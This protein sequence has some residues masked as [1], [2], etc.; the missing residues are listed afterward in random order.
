M[1]I[2]RS[3]APR[4]LRLAELVVRSAL[5]VARRSGWVPPRWRTPRGTARPAPTTSSIGIVD[6]PDGGVRLVGVRGW[7]GPPEVQRLRTI[8]RE[9]PRGRALHLDLAGA[10][11]WPHHVA[12]HLTA[13]LEAAEGRGVRIRVV[14]LDAATSQ[15]SAR[16]TR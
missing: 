12:E 7:I 10:G 9:L 5:G 15:V 6:D 2:S 11:I 13:V 3:P 4:H 14:G 16:R 1:S 8:V